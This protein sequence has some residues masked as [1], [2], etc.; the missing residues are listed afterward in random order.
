MKKQDTVFVAGGTGFVGK[1][2]IEKLKKIKI[3]FITTSLSGGTDFRDFADTL[4][5]FEKHRPQ[6]VIHTAAYIGGIKF[7]IDHAGEIYFDNI[8][9]STNL[10]EA[11]RRTG[12]RK[13][14]SPIANCAYPD[15]WEGTLKEENFWNGKIHDSVLP[16]GVVRKAQ[17]AQTWAYHRQYGMNFVNLI[18]PNMYGPGDYFD[19]ERS[20]ALG[21]LLM[22]TAEAKRAH[23]PTVTVWGTG[24]P[25]R[26]WLYVEDGAEALV[27]AIDIEYPV[28]PINI[29]V[30]KGISVKE[31]AELIARIVGYAGKLVFDPSKPDGTAY[32]VMSNERCR[33]IF[34]WIPLTKLEDGI[35]KTYEWYRDGD[36]KRT[37]NSL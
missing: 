19:M 20:H 28:E 23:T 9:I 8:L 30:G 31:L 16:Y 7:G 24:K 34:R 21:A 35:R 11:A 36:K 14:I 6:I 10:I 12:V 18:L 1:A 5:Y 17:W 3:P 26:E 22:K 13:F 33:K 27:R 2:V 32:K 29:G 15:V 25:V 4:A 37:K